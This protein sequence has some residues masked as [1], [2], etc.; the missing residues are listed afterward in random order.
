MNNDYLESL[1]RQLLLDV[2]GFVDRG[3]ESYSADHWTWSLK[4]SEWHNAEISITQV[5][6]GSNP[7]LSLDFA[8]VV[9]G[10][11]S[12]AELDLACVLRAAMSGRLGLRAV[13]YA[14]RLLDQFVTFGP[15]DEA[16]WP[17]PSRALR[18][19]RAQ[20]LEVTVCQVIPLPI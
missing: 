3:S 13:Y 1:R 15:G 8:G 9:E 18:K 16:R 6:P 7:L 19:A 20:G 17:S 4:L 5:S 14:G 11:A 2:S 10:E 12:A